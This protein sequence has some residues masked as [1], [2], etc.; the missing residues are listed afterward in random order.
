MFDLSGERGRNRTYNLLIKSLFWAFSTLRRFVYCV[1]KGLRMKRLQVGVL[2]ARTDEFSRL[3]S[4]WHTIGTLDCRSPPARLGTGTS[5]DRDGRRRRQ[6]LAHLRGTVSRRHPDRRSVSRSTAPLGP[7]RQTSS[8]RREVQTKVGDDPAASSGNRK[9]EKLVAKLRSLASDNAELVAG[10]R[11]TT[12]N[13]TRSECSFASKIYFAG[14]GVIEAGCK[15]GSRLKHS[16]VF[17]TVRGANAV[18]A[19][20]CCRYSRHFDDYWER[21]R[22]EPDHLSGEPDS[23]GYVGLLPTVGDGV[24]STTSRDIR[25]L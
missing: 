13:G 11:R 6:D 24:L 14:S 9:I 2:I 21:Q 18:I 4:S 5:Q 16:G 17:W 10:S 7:R 15:T 8:Q 3:Q 1:Y 23:L 20:R 25:L 19:C 12:S 22:A